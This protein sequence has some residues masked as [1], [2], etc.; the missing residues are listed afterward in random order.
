M[1]IRTCGRSTKSGQPCRQ[2]LHGMMYRA[3]K[4][5]ETPEDKA[6]REGYEASLRANWETYERYRQ[7]SKDFWIEEGKRQARRETQQEARRREE[8]ASFRLKDFMGRQIVQV[9]LAEEG[10]PKNAYAY[11]WGGGELLA[12]GDYVRI[13]SPWSSGETW[14][15]EVVGLGTSYTGSLKTVIS[16]VLA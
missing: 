16:K 13:Q 6:Y 10:K 12:I 7:E 14:K 9:N 4:I 11:T 5:H 8:E 3:C 1:E 2:Q 15:V